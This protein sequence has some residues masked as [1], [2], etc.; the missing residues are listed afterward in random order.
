MTSAF[1]LAADWAL[2][3][4]LHATAASIL[5]LAAGRWLVADPKLRD[6]LWKAAL[7]LPL[8]TSLLFVTASPIVS[9]SVDLASLARPHLPPALRSTQVLAHVAG[10]EAPPTID[11]RDATARGLRYAILGMILIPAVVAVSRMTR[12]HVRFRRALRTRRVLDAQAFALDASGLSLG[13]NVVRISVSPHVGTA[14]AVARGEICVSSAF[15]TLG[16]A[17]RRAVLAH[18]I[19]HLERGDLAWIA[20]AD[21]VAGVLAAQ[22]LV[23]MVARRLR[24]DAEFICDDIA[25]SRTGDAAAYVRALA[26]FAGAYGASPPLALAYGSS[27]IVQRAERV[28]GV[29]AA[30]RRRRACVATAFV[31]MMLLGGLLTLPRVRTSGANRTVRTQVNARSVS[32]SSAHERIT[33][34]LDVR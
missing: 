16:P 4:L 19:A 6:L 31:A 18:E 11:V 14:A 33:V 9:H 28:L 30:G 27:P 15:T 24:R 8:G 12:V 1:A 32:G 17:E 34:R 3:W 21:A 20:F 2:S 22:P 23:G 10:P 5:T 26:V 13:G 7:V 29:H 25:V